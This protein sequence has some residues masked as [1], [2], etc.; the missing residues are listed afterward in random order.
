MSQC[1]TMKRPYLCINVDGQMN[2]SLQY[3]S[4]SFVMGVMLTIM[5]GQNKLQCP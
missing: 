1:L 5:Q 4:S 3:C 2:I